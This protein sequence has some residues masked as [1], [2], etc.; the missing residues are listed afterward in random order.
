MF[1]DKYEEIEFK[2]DGAGKKR[3]NLFGKIVFFKTKDQ[4]NCICML[5]SHW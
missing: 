1:I 3:T 5:S 2:N 4:K